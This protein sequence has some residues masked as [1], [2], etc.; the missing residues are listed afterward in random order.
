MT[1][2]IYFITTP[3]TTI[4]TLLGIY[5]VMFW[6]FKANPVR[7][8]E[9]KMERKAKKKKKVYKI[10]I[11]CICKCVHQQIKNRT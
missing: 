2:F 7:G 3:S 4:K 8:R 5:K 6:T 10:K 9:K 11:L 1:E